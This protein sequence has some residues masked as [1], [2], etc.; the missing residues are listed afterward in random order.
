MPGAVQHQD[1]GEKISAAEKDLRGERG[2]YSSDLSDMNK[3]FPPGFL[4]R[5][6]GP[7]FAFMEVSMA[8]DNKRY[9]PLGVTKRL[10]IGNAKAWETVRKNKTPGAL[11]LLIRPRRIQNIICLNFNISL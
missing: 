6:T 7:I 10:Y 4:L 1:F 2:L 3:R 8:N 5:E 9:I 11:F